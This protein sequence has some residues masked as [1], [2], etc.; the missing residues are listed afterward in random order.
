LTPALER[1]ILADIFAWAV[2]IDA[3]PETKKSSNALVRRGA[4]GKDGQ[5]VRIVPV[6]K[7]GFQQIS[8]YQHQFL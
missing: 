2:T 1:K 4:Q 5:C 6:L 7:I 8:N 3:I